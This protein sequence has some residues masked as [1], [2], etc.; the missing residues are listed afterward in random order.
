MVDVERESI[1]VA[2]VE[3]VVKADETVA[4][5]QATAAQVSA[6]CQGAAHAIN[7]TLLKS[8]TNFSA[9]SLQYIFPSNCFLQLTTG[10]YFLVTYCY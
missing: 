7:S 10:F 2:K 5:E 1:E 3:K 6:I 8:R 4:N 9:C